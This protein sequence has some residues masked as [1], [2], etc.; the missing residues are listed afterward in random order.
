MAYPNWFA[1]YADKYFEFHLLHDFGGK[2]DL[3]FL[4]IGAF[5]GD[6]SVWLLEHF[7][8]ATL[9]DVDTWAGSDEPFHDQFNWADVEKTYDERMI[10]RPVWKF[11]GT[12][13]DFF[14]NEDPDPGSYDFIYIDGDHTAPGVLFDA[15]NAVPLLKVGGLIA[16]DDYEWTSGKGR[17]HDPGPAIDAIVDIYANSLKSAGKSIPAK[18]IWLRRYA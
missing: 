11:K 3:R 16:F 13:R 4:Q 1:C 6:A 15:V 9:T 18:Q 17:L 8:S 5:T 10:G 7:P 2:P 14:R 12:S